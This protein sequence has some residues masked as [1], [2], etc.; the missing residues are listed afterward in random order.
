VDGL[1][2]TSYVAREVIGEAELVDFTVKQSPFD[3]FTKK[4]GASVA[5]RLAVLVGLQGPSLR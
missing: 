5:E 4:L 3:R 1:G 2:S